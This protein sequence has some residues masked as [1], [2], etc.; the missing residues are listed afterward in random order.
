MSEAQYANMHKT[1]VVGST[2]YSGQS[3]G[4]PPP[5]ETESYRSI[6]PP[7]ANEHTH[8]MGGMH[9]NNFYSNNSGAPTPASSPGFPSPAYTHEMEPAGGVVRFVF[10]FPKSTITHD[11]FVKLRMAVPHVNHAYVSL[12]VLI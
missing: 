1:P 5:T 9:P 2:H 11:F 3:Y 10:Q 7:P 12:S 8:M 6:S 4:G